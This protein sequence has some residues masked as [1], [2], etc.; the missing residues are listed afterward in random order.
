M[1]IYKILYSTRSNPYST[2]HT[3]AT[4]AIASGITPD[5]VALWIGDEVATVL[6]HYCHPNVVEA[7]CPDF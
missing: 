7:D 6:K 1:S 2:R 4:W 5:K 3:F